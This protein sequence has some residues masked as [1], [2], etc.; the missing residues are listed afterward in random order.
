VKNYRIND[1]QSTIVII[2][3]E[4]K[5]L[6]ENSLKNT[7]KINLGKVNKKIYITKV[8]L[9]LMKIFIS[10]IALNFKNKILRGK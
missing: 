5:I 9:N 1:I 8:R 4:F 2:I 3:M 7:F 6:I 10:K